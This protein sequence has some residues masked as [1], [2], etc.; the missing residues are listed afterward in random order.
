MRLP[1]T[2]EQFLEVFKIYNQAVFPAQ[3]FFNLVA[4]ISIFLI[5][6]RTG[7]ANKIV[8]FFLSFFWI[9]MGIAYHI[10][11]FSKVNELAFV[12]GG[13]FVLQGIIFIISGILKD[14]LSFT[15][16]FSVRHILGLALLVF[17]LVIY[18]VLSYF[19]G[20]IYPYSP[21]FGLPCPTTIFTLGLLCWMEKKT[22]WYVFTIPVL[23]S[24]IGF[25]AAISLD[26]KEDIGLLVAGVIFLISQVLP[27]KSH[28]SLF[29]K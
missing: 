2:I 19:S 22:P 8:S 21:S 6:K 12:F 27:R 5:I 17:A 26:M 20:H 7:K 10:L 24:V 18:P 23:W 11:F 25:S 1:F 28:Q 16:E 9:W 14:S 3:I 15:F 4:V 29:T 13:I